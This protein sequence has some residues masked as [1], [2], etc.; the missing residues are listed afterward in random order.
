MHGPKV[1]WAC[2]AP[3]PDLGDR[4][5][6]TGTVSNG[7]QVSAKVRRLVCTIQPFTVAALGRHS[8]SGLGPTTQPPLSRLSAPSVS[9]GRE[10][11]TGDTGRK[12]ATLAKAT[13]EPQKVKKR[14]SGCMGTETPLSLWE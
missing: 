4:G 1:Q 2:P 3:G 10:F 12:Q 14:I 7:P 6:M 8:T 5:Q 11:Q 13:S 9:P